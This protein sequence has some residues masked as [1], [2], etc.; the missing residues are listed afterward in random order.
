MN[1]YH[2]SQNSYKFL[3]DIKIKEYIHEVRI[4][5]Y[6]DTS[7]WVGCVGCRGVHHNPGGCVWCQYILTKNPDYQFK[8]VRFVVNNN[9]I[10]DI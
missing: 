2:E 4:E 8:T 5:D 6:Y 7:D 3:S 9:K 10:S 1:L